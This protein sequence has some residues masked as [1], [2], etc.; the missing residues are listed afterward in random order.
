[1][2]SRGFLSCRV[3]FTSWL[4]STA[5]V[6]CAG[7]P[8]PPPRE[9]PYVSIELPPS[10]RNFQV[11]ERGEKHKR[12]QVRFEMAPEDLTLFVGRLPCRL[13]P[14]QR[15]PPRH[16]LVVDNDQVWY[17]PEKATRHRGCDNDRPGGWQRSSFLMDLGD[18]QKIVVYAVLE[19]DW[20]R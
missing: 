4:A 12:V 13:D 18:A 5:L 10:A 20:T 6:A 2:S 17:T 16:A 9:I 14:E 3:V 8:P 19:L 15:E 7:A 1:M 11:H